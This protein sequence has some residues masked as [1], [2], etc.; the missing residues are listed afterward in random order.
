MEKTKTEKQ[1]GKFKKLVTK[2]REK[3]TEFFKGKDPLL[4]IRPPF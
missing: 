2:A 4:E 3:I 1:P